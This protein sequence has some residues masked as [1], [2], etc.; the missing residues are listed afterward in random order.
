MKT[1][2]TVAVLASLCVLA[3]L[4]PSC[5]WVDK[6][7]YVKTTNTVV[8]VEGKTNQVVSIQPNPVVETQIRAVGGAVGGL[9]GLG[10]LAAL[11]AGSV[12]HTYCRVRNRNITGALVQ[13]IETA[14]DVLS[15]TPQG[16]KL[17]AAMVDWLKKH[18]A[19]AGIAEAVATL[20]KTTVHNDAAQALSQITADTIKKAATQP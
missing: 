7:L 20:L 9:W 8:T 1:K 10:P 17:D 4:A 12:Y 16:E 3:V 19:E 13:E 15:T 18:Q 5:A 11:L 2:V 14:R 6:T